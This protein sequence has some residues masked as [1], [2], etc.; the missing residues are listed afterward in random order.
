MANNV[1]VNLRTHVNE[2]DFGIVLV[3]F[4]VRVQLKDHSR[5]VMKQKAMYAHS[6]AGINVFPT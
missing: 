4:L 5:R 3:A 1:R 6:R 2:I